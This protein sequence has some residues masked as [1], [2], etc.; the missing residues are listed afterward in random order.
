MVPISLHFWSLWS[1]LWICLMCVTALSG[2]QFGTWVM[3]SPMVLLSK[4]W[5]CCLFSDASMCILELNPGFPKQLHAVAFLSSSLCM[6]WLVLWFPR[7]SLSGSSARK[8]R[9]LVTLL[10]CA[11]LMTALTS[12]AKWQEDRGKKAIGF[13]PPP[14]NHSSSPSSEF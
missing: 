13:N 7:A 9:A 1:T 14:W 4:S 8:D 3:I 11:L 10:G 2:G 5:V 6:I 12:G